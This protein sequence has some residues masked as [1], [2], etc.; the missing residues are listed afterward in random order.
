MK[1][2]KKFKYILQTKNSENLDIK[3]IEGKEFQ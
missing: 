2:M 1:T 3:T